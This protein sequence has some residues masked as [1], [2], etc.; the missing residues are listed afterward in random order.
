V[1]RRVVV[2]SE[3][4][5]LADEYR[6]LCELDA[7]IGAVVTFCGLVR[8]CQEQARIDSLTLQHYPGMTEASLN[9]VVVAAEQRWPLHGVSV[10][11]RVGALLP[12]DQIVFVG[13]ASSHRAAAFQA[14]DF[15]MDYLKTHALL[16]KRVE[17]DG[18][19][20]WVE[21]RDSDERALQRW[22]QSST[23]P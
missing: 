4:F 8:D 9:K 3:D 18:Q 7:A 1:S 11:H 23:P 12:S 19:R 15:L 17:S 10:I 13:V 20:S 14:A 2:Q 6:R 21:T 22:T 16:W 5:D